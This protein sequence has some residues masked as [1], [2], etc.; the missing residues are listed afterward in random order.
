MYKSVCVLLADTCGVRERIY[1]KTGVIT[2]HWATNYGAVLQSY[3]LCRY[4]SDLG[5]DVR[6]ID[7]YPFKYKKTFIQAFLTKHLKL[8]PSRLKE[9]S[10]EKQIESFRSKHLNRTQYFSRGKKLKD[11]DFD[12][13]ICGSDQIWN[14]SFLQYGERGMAYSYFLDFAP[15]EKII[16]SYAASFGTARYKEHLKPHIK[17]YLNR[18]DFIS[19][20]ENT[21]IDILND[22][23]IEDCRV[24][25]DPTLLLEKADYEKLLLPNSKENKYN[26]VYMLHRKL[27]D[28]ENVMKSLN[29]NENIVCDNIGIEE[30]L[31][32]IYYAEH[33]ITNSFHGVVFSII[34][35]KP[36][37]ALM[38][39]GSG[40]NDRLITLLDRLGLS[41]RISK[42]K[43]AAV[44][45]PI[46][47]ASVKEKLKS[48]RQTGYDYLNE[49][50]NYEKSIIDEN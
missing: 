7:Y 1:M 33:I 37:T 17:K 44:T 5:N 43:K 48:F 23:G 25:P 35:E 11:F 34:F 20:R 12:C 16:A 13:Y 9:I 41:D 21:G 42:D 50:I 32:N 27:S 2:F 10:K 36:F 24:V 19:V 18:F 4:L 46:D 45:S 29:E 14:E 40:M 8:I 6:I 30:W 39:D 28:A 38:I 15:E 22:I 49:I 47:Y 26:F 3:A 31:T